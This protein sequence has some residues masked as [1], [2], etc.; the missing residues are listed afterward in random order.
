MSSATLRK[1]DGMP[2]LSQ[3]KHFDPIPRSSTLAM[4]QVGWIGA[5]GEVYALND[6]PYDQREPGS[7]SP[8]YMSIGCWEDL[9]D[10]HYAI[11]D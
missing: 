8:L 2:I 4:V 1:S 3:N 11:K 6:P 9:G 7:F 5:T 10:G